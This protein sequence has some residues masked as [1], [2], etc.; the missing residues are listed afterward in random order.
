MVLPLKL[1]GYQRT[2]EHGVVEEEAEEG[3]LPLGVWTKD[4]AAGEVST[5]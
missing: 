2:L 5:R 1:I 3:A 4:P